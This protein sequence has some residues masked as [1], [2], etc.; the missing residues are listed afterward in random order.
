MSW[1][2][3]PATPGDLPALVSFAQIQ[4]PKRDPQFITRRWWVSSG[5]CLVAV[6]ENGAIDGIC[7]AR[8]QRVW[9]GDRT[10]TAVGICDWYVGGRARGA[11]IGRALAEEACK[12]ADLCWSLSLSAAAETAFHRLGWSP[13]PA[14]RVPLFLAPTPVVAL[15]GLRG[16]VVHS[17][18]SMNNIHSVLPV[19]CGGV[20]P[21]DWVCGMRDPQAWREHLALV[22]NRSYD[23]HKVP[24]GAF[25]VSRRL[26]AGAF[27]RLG[28]QRVTLV[29]ELI[30]EEGVAELLGA[31]ARNALVHGST[32]MLLPLLD[33]RIHRAIARSG[34]W[35]AVDGFGGVRLPR[36]GTRF[37]F[38]FVV[39]REAAAWRIS[40]L[41]CDF[42]LTFGSDR[43]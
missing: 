4:W 17:T 37:M 2:L 19:V 15:A 6:D 30:G 39:P 42:D 21:R 33:P 20:I 36:L 3:R 1:T 14:L 31:I 27:P 23:L 40:A 5:Q 8:R 32:V 34:L 9:L 13:A 11:K 24:N 22:P 16:S 7:G 29:S 10:G 43:E 26:A 12:G 38:R 41:D 18:F 35:S 25:A 28:P